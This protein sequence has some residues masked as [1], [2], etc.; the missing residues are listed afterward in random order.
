MPRNAQN[1]TNP[2]IAITTS[3]PKSHQPHGTRRSS[4]S[5]RSNGRKFSVPAGD[6]QGSGVGARLLSAAFK[7]VRAWSFVWDSELGAGS[8]EFIFSSLEFISLRA[9]HSQCVRL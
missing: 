6:P 5:E 4:G 3:K 8:E 2:A 1:K 7:A 9:W